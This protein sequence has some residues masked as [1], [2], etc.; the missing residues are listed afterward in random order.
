MSQAA[1]TRGSINYLES[2]QTGTTRAGS[3]RQERA[4]VPIKI[5]KQ[6]DLPEHHHFFD[7]I[8][9]KIDSLHA[10]LSVLGDVCSP[11]FIHWLI[12]DES[13]NK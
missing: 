13:D 5:S 10:F 1:L 9:E 6:H 3:T 2:Q 11:L 7:S 4:D 8:N 12:G